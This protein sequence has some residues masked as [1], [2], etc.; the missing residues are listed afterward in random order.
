MGA[1]VKFDLDKSSVGNMIRLEDYFTGRQ[2]DDN[3][4]LRMQL[5]DS[6]S[7]AIPHV[8]KD[9]Q[10]MYFG[11]NTADGENPIVAFGTI[12]IVNASLGIVDFSFPNGAFNTVGDFKC[13]FCI[14]DG[15]GTRLT[16]ND[17]TFRV[18]PDYVDA[19]INMTPYSSQLS[20]WEAELASTYSKASSDLATLLSEIAAS[21][22]A[23]L[24][25]NNIFTGSNAFSK[26]ITAPDVT[27][28]KGEV[29]ALFDAVGRG[30]VQFLTPK[31]TPND[32]TKIVYR[33]HMA[34]LNDL[35][36]DG[37]GLALLTMG[38]VYTNKVGQPKGTA[39][40]MGTFDSSLPISG[41]VTQTAPHTVLLATGQM[42]R[43]DIHSNRQLI[44]SS[45]WTRISPGATIDINVMYG[46]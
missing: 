45:A 4:Y 35:M 26:L 30:N 19:Y 9:G 43:I 40:N 24:P 7:P 14:T 23:L 13:F 36:D 42:G 11:A 22:V 2:G 41:S 10:S 31:F 5:Y 17:C 32:P 34:V 1:I 39:F 27:T 15:A 46:F 29:S 25:G 37:H 44:L 16:T 12:N 18:T 33:P 3:S 28:D 8:F 20:K 6:F 21:K 38:L